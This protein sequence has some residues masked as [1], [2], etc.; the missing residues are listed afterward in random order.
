[1]ASAPATVQ[2]MP[3]RLHRVPIATLQP[4]STTPVEVHSPA[5]RKAG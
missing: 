1:M 3:A 2:C 5:A 4:A